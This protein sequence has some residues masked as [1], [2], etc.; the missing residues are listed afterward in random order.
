M[1]NPIYCQIQ[2]KEHLSAQWSD[3]LGG[4]EIENHPD[5]CATLRGQLADQTALY[6]LLNRLRDLGVSLVS[7]NCDELRDDDDKESSSTI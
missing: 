2:I 5:G 7:L 1:N 4:F 6:S 3:W